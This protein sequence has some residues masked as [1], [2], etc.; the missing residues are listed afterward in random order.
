MMTTIRTLFRSDMG[1]PVN[2]KRIKPRRK[3]EPAHMAEVAKHPCLVCGMWPVE[4]HHVRTGNQSKNDRRVVPLCE[5]H[6]RDSRMGF[7]GL[8][9]ERMFYAEHGINLSAEA[10]RLEAE[11]VALGKL[12]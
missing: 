2:H 12:K 7:H 1:A 10:E 6:H 4:V 8:G 3:H 11:S 9:S 5:F